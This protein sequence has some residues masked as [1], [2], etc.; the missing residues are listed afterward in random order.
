MRSYAEER[1]GMKCGAIRVNT[2]VIK[3]VAAKIRDRLGLMRYCLME[4]LTQFVDKSS[5]LTTFPPFWYGNERR[6]GPIQLASKPRLNLSAFAFLG[7]NARNSKSKSGRSGILL[8]TLLH[9]GK[10]GALH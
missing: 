1:C 3:T 9:S 7:I 2:M 8:H 5:I 4:D 6:S 10:G